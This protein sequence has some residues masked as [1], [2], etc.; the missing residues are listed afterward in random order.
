MK[1]EGQAWAVAQLGEITAVSPEAF[2]LLEIIDP[3][4]ENEGMTVVVSVNCKPFERREGGIPL[5]ARERLRISVP[6]DFPLDRP[7]V[8]FTHDRYGAFAHV[9]WGSSICLHQA[10]DVEW[11]AT[12]GMFGFM[13]RLGEWLEA[14]AAGELDPVGM[15]LHPPV[16]YPVAN[17]RVVPT[18]NAP[19]PTETYWSG[20]VEIPREASH[21][22]ELGRWIEQS[23]EVP[24][25]RLASVI[26]LPTTMP[27][28]YP[29]TVWD[30]IVALMERG[31]SLTMIRLLMTIGVLRTGEGKCAIFVL[32]AAM[33]GVSG[34]RL[35]QHLACWRMDVAQTDKLRAAAIARTDDNPIDEQ[36]FYAWAFEAK[37]EWCRVLE[38]RPEIVER[39]DSVSPAAYWRG[40][41]V[42][43]MGCGAIGSAVAMMLAKA[44]V[45]KLRLYDNNVVTPGVLVRQ[46]FDRRQIAYTKS[47]ATK[48]NVEAAVPGINVIEAHADVAQALTDEVRS[49]GADSHRHRA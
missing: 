45:A 41:S 33:R 31:V 43:L 16:A 46:G 15:P 23:E 39:R 36:V 20:Y 1:S 17:F 19:E 26:L 18:Q 4:R 8:N 40:K 32:G 48:V 42:T 3:A 27:F 7:T 11:Q 37:V 5:K 9:Q 25:I 47:S 14:G 28:E 49:A 6:W 35:L 13:Q 38:D 10:P 29:T 12:R 34:G 21:A 22:A 30:L 44:G 24:D 2:E